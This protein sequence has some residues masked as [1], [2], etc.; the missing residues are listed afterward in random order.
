MPLADARIRNPV[1]KK[2]ISLGLN[3]T[4][5]PNNSVNGRSGSVCTN[6]STSHTDTVQSLESF[7]KYCS[8]WLNFKQSTAPSHYL[9]LRRAHFSWP[10]QNS[11]YSTRNSKHN[12]IVL[13]KYYLAPPKMPPPIYTSPSGGKIAQHISQK[14]VSENSELCQ[15]VPENASAN[16]N[17]HEHHFTHDP[18]P[19]RFKNA[20]FSLRPPLSKSSF[21]SIVCKARLPTNIL[22]NGTAFACT[23]NH[24]RS[25]HALHQHK[26]SNH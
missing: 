23:H 12:N 3:R 22:R 14:L 21:S 26:K 18:A 24:C 10:F 17:V 16:M 7:A 1:V 25:V 13:C 11:Q 4:H 15:F 20:I 5:A 9:Y 6:F 2:W 8:S 19:P